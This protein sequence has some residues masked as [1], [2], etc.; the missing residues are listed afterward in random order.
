MAQRFVRQLAQKLP[1]I[2]GFKTRLITAACRL[3]KFGF[4][5]TRWLRAKNQ[6][7]LTLADIP[8][9]ARTLI[10]KPCCLGDV[11]LASATIRAISQA[12][13][14][15]KLEFLVSEWSRV[16]LEHNPRL[17][18]L[19]PTGVAGSEFS[20]R[21]FLS[22]ARRL[23]REKY[24]AVFVL[25]R[26][27]RLNLLGWLA[28]IPFRA[29][30]DSQHR[31][32][33]LNVRAT[34]SQTL[35]SEA[36]V[37]LDVARAAGI[38]VENPRLE[39]YPGE[40]NQRSVEQ[41]AVQ[42]GINWQTQLAVIHPGGG[43]NPDTK[44]LSKR[45]PAERFGEIARRLREAGWQVVVIGAN[46]DRELVEKV[47]AASGA[48]DACEKFSFA[49]IGALLS[50]TKLFIG[51]D[52]GI[53]HLAAACGAAVVAVYGPSS[54][55]AYVP[56]AAKAATVAPLA[57]GVRAGLP[58]KEY[59]RLSAAEG[60]IYSVSVEQV[61]QALKTLEPALENEANPVK[62]TLNN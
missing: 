3:L 30:L 48:I 54:P 31:G 16:T 57:P 4:D 9:G 1:K 25:D 22:L 13:P 27:P 56:F 7:N 32:F 49:E 24:A 53:M 45:W 18:K 5:S 12:R 39:F 2:S 40:A 8:Q 44:V 51:N 21:Q 37:Y 15:L 17:T 46:T 47:I 26:S 62:P 29:G 23:R 42:L 38:S 52:T 50:Q 35:K 11:I 55:V 34:V 20:W 41:K 60:G 61:W 19:V 58:L 6:Q 28:G 59:E 33:A 36:E 43:H 14:D 10:V